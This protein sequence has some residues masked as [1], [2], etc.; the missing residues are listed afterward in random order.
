MTVS[1]TTECYGTTT[2]SHMT[3]NTDGRQLDAV[4]GADVYSI[5]FTIHPH[6]SFPISERAYYNYNLRI[7]R[8]LLLN[9]AVKLLNTP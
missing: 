5:E 7:D 3:M 8:L 6:N 4:I 2:F 1:Y 9:L